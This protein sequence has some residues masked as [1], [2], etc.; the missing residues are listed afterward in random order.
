MT[1]AT[2]RTNRIACR[3]STSP[4]TA[5][6]EGPRV[7]FRHQ[8][9]GNQMPTLTAGASL[10]CAFPRQAQKGSSIHGARRTLSL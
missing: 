9:S 8:G 1:S 4:W 3:R 5:R 7:Y 6:A 2:A 10:H